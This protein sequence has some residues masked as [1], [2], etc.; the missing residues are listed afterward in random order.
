MLTANLAMFK[1]KAGNK[2]TKDQLTV[3]INDQ[4]K[5]EKVEKKVG[6]LTKDRLAPFQE[7]TDGAKPAQ[8]RGEKTA[9]KV[10]AADSQDVENQEM[11]ESWVDTFIGD[12]V[13]TNTMLRL[14]FAEAL[15]TDP[16]TRD[17]E[18]GGKRIVGEEDFKEPASE[19]D[20]VGSQDSILTVVNE[21]FGAETGDGM[22][23]PDVAKKHLP[24]F[25]LALATRGLHGSKR[26]PKN[27]DVE[28]GSG[29]MMYPH[30]AR[31]YCLRSYLYGRM[32]S[33]CTTQGKATLVVD[34]LG[35][36]ETWSNK[37]KGSEGMFQIALNKLGEKMDIEQAKP[38][39]S[40]EAV[41]VFVLWCS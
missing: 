39:R 36:F 19:K 35:D 17:D 32:T 21:I 7:E 6:T 27:G 10:D 41:V 1:E 37:D 25:W 24:G 31:S 12:A 22:L 38:V 20:D 11:I 33:I 14:A 5:E 2:L 29:N 30:D 13:G 16:R 3:G 18:E 4:K 9:Q 15:D 26:D 28:F 34:T 40:V 8:G 23:S